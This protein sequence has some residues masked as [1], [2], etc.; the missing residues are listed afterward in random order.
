MH[1]DT[2]EDAEI[3][4]LKMTEDI[5]IMEEA[6]AL[7]F[8]SLTETQKS[9]Q[10]LSEPMLPKLLKT[11]KRF[12]AMKANVESRKRQLKNDRKSFVVFICSYHSPLPKAAPV[13]K[14]KMS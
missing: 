2:Q 14:R 13:L 6:A 10:K 4:I 7:S 9:K 8:H 1:R 5:R 11:V 12:I 3:N